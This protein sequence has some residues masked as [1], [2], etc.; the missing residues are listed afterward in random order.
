MPAQKAQ[1]R[2]K[3]FDGARLPFTER[4]SVLLR[5]H[6]GQTTQSFTKTLNTKSLNEGE[7]LL[8]VDFFDNFADNYTVLISADDY[9]DAGFF[10][11]KVSPKSVRDLSLM[12]VPKDPSFAFDPWDVVK[13]DHPKV[14][15]FLSLT[16]GTGEAPNCPVYIDGEHVKTLRGTYDE[17]AREF[18][19]LVD[20][21]VETRYTRRSR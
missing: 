14:A 9:R 12:L 6:N 2:L 11:V 15:Q 16:P 20:D 5:V 8:E 7:V 18:Q 3:I 4:Q 1:I 19:Q 21:Y 17:L 10:P 13:A